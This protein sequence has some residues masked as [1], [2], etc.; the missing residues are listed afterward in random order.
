MR[1]DALVSPT[2]FG[3]CALALL[4]LFSTPRISIAQDAGPANLTPANPISI[5]QMP[6]FSRREN[7]SSAMHHHRSPHRPLAR[8]GDPA[9]DDQLHA[10]RHRPG[11]ASPGAGHAAVAAQSDAHRPGH[12]H[13]LP[14]HGQNHF[15]V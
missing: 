11:P 13:D 8:P 4:V 9:D 12:V 6:D 10:H 1:K 15:S 7:F 14:G 3:L 2:S 5:P